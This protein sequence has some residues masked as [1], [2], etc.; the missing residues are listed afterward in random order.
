MRC[1]N[2][3][4]GMEDEELAMVLVTALAACLGVAMEYMDGRTGEDVVRHDSVSKDTLS[5]APPG[6]PS[7]AVVDMEETIV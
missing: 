7:P 5:N 6:R 4:T 1:D 3:Q 2:Q